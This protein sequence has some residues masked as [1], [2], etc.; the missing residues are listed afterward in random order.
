MKKKCGEVPATNMAELH[1]SSV[2]EVRHHRPHACDSVREAVSPNVCVSSVLL[3]SHAEISLLPITSFF[4]LKPHHVLGAR[5]LLSS[6]E[7]T[8]VKKRNRLRLLDW[9]NTT[10]GL[11]PFSGRYIF[12]PC[13]S[14]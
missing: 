1:S 13:T 8:K 7:N 5:M 3:R 11:V 14:Q 2:T 4:S 6:L 9:F 10:M 12:P